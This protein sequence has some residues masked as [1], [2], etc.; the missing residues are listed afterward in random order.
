MG[1]VMS[2]ATLE[3]AV[4]STRVVLA[5]VQQDQLGADTPCASWTV[6]ALINHIVGG[7]F[8]FATLAGGGEPSGDAPPDFAAGDFVAAFDQGS[9]AAVEAF[10]A[11]GVMETVMH[12]PFGDMPGSVFIGIAATDT[13]VHGWDLARATGQSSDLDPALAGGLLAGVRPAIPDAF[14]GADG[15]APFGPEQPA[16]EGASNADQLAAFLGR[17]V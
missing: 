3:Q 1:N 6:S 11:D 8:Y 14:R 15:Q 17:T 5:G 9:A 10:R 13:F 2:T 12:L 7:Q 16:P 4:K